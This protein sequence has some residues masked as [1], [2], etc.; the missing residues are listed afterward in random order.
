MSGHLIP[1]PIIIKQILL[2]TTFLREY[3][4]ILISINYKF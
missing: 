1:S 2:T 3:D 4:I